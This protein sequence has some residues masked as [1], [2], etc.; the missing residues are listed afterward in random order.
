MSWEEIYFRFLLLFCPIFIAVI[1]YNGINT[2]MAD[3]YNIA[4]MFGRI[5]AIFIFFDITRLINR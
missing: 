4:R 3:A 1:V 2:N 5:I